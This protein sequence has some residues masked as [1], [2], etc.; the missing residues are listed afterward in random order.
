MDY[1]SWVAIETALRVQLRDVLNAKSIDDIALLKNTSE[2][3]SVVAYG[4]PWHPGDNVVT[5][6]QEF[7]SNRIPWE[8][9]APL[10]VELREVSVTGPDVKRRCWTR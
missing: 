10:G 2:A 4:L 5:T 1:P 3:L 6:D 8:S 7:P 9:L